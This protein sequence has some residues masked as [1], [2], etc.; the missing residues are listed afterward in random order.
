[1]IDDTTR[2]SPAEDGPAAVSFTTYAGTYLAL[3]LLATGSL[4]LSSLHLGGLAVA[5]PIAGLK[6]LLVLWFFMH[7]S[8]QSASSRLAVLVAVV[9]I[10]VLVVLTALDVRTR[11]TFPARAEPPPASGFYRRSAP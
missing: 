7:L 6:A 5:L 1:M 10:G 9:L 4:L 11:H 8:T 3:L 2:D